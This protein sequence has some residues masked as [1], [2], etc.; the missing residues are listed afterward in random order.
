MSRTC[1]GLKY[2]KNFRNTISRL[3]TRSEDLGSF[4]RFR[5]GIYLF[6]GGMPVAFKLISEFFF[7]GKAE[8]GG[9]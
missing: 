8:S 6:W 7:E 2:C 3:L 4:H 5:G 9:D 1:N